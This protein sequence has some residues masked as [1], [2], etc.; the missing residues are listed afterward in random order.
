MTKEK[1]NKKPAQ[2]I[3]FS[4][5]ADEYSFGNCEFEP[6]APVLVI[7]GRFPENSDLAFG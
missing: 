6:H 1:Q 7:Q 2:V 3:P 4:Q 5:V